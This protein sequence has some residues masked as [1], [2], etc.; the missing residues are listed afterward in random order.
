M[1]RCEEAEV[2]MDGTD[3]NVGLNEMDCAAEGT[4]FSS[5]SMSIIDAL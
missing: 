2:L 3:N 5:Q 1:E 4:Q